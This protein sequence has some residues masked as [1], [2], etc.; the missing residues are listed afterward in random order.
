MVSCSTVMIG[1]SPAD[2][3]EEH[4]EDRVDDDDREEA[5]HDGGG[6]R[7]ADA[8]GTAVRGESALTG[9]ERHTEA[10]ENGL[11]TAGKNVPQSY[12]SLHLDE[13]GVGC[14]IEGEHGHQQAA[15]DA[16]EIGHD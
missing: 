2:G 9:D 12:G 1:A 6:R 8:F 7:S 13:I 16:D 15:G 4:R 10:E 14:E 5:G 3:I 11:Q